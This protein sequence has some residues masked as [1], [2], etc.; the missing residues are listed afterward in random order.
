[1]SDRCCHRGIWQKWGQC[2]GLRW[3]WLV[4]HRSAHCHDSK[5]TSP[6][7]FIYIVG[8]VEVGLPFVRLLLFCICTQQGSAHPFGLLASCTP[9]LRDRLQLQRHHRG[10][11]GYNRCRLDHWRWWGDRQR[12][13]N[14]DLLVSGWQ[15][16]TS[17]SVKRRGWLWSTW[18]SESAAIKNDLGFVLELRW[19]A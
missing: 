15:T 19:C 13:Q 10:F 2:L 12:G 8:N 6:C 3:C 7:S 18:V 4:A 17:G 16:S 5:V 9:Q 14:V 1:M 11:W